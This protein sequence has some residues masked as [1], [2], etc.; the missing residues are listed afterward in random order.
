MISL[1]LRDE[2]K[3]PTGR[4]GYHHFC[5]QERNARAFLVCFPLTGIYHAGPETQQAVSHP[6]RCITFQSQA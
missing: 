3:K 2:K 1:A 5:H 4:N 6:W